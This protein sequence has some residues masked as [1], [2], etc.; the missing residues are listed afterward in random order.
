MNKS[1]LILTG[2]TPFNSLET[3]VFELS[4]QL[5]DITFTLQSIQPSVTCSVNLRLVDFISEARFRDYDLIITH[6]GAGTVFFLLAC[7]LPF[8]AVP[9]LERR[10]PHQLELYNWLRKNKYSQTAL[11]DELKPDLIIN[12]HIQTNLIVDLPEFKLE[13]LMNELFH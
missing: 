12:K 6:A 11:I 1:V 3:R 5:P 7:N 10:D 4:K 2:N 8:I 9:N 13:M